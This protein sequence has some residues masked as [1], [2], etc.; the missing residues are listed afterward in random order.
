MWRVEPKD[1]ALCEPHLN[2]VKRRS[3]L[4]LT[5]ATSFVVPFYPMGYASWSGVGPRTSWRA[6]LLRV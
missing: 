5:V 1:D 4:L 2:L 6:L 3:N